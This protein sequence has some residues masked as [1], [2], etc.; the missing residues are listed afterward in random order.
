MPVSDQHANS[1]RSL[2]KQISAS[3][4]NENIKEYN[5]R[6][7]LD[8]LTRAI[9]LL[10]GQDQALQQATWEDV[11]RKLDLAHRAVVA[12]QLKS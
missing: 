9:G 3:A 5:L 6:I 10:A 12:T 1:V 4:W 11:E 7:A 2:A 8:L